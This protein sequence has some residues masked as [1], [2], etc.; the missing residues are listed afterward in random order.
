METLELAVVTPSAV[1]HWRIPCQ[2]SAN[3][4]SAPGA[5]Q[6]QKPFPVFSRFKPSADRGRM[7]V[8][9]YDAVS[10]SDSSPLWSLLLTT[11]TATADASSV[12]AVGGG[13]GKK[14]GAEVLWAQLV[15]VPTKRQVVWE[16]S[17][18][19]LLP[20]PETTTTFQGT[21]AAAA[22]AHVE[23]GV[24]V[25]VLSA[26]GA[27]LAVHSLNE[28]FLAAHFS[29]AGAVVSAG[30]PP[31]PAA[32]S[33]ASSS[34]SLCDGGDIG[35]DFASSSSPEGV[36]E[37]Q[38]A[39]LV[40]SAVGR[41][42]HWLLPVVPTVAKGAA[43]DS[44]VAHSSAVAVFHPRGKLQLI[45]CPL[46]KVSRDDN[47]GFYGTETSSWAVLYEGASVFGEGEHKKGV[48]LLA[49]APDFRDPRSFLFLAATS[50]DVNVNDAE[51]R[52]LKNKEAKRVAV[53]RASFEALLE[54]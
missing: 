22:H 39:G 16:V 13:A 25:V 35:D 26:G 34:L 46:D 23:G 43:E 54:S 50:V 4:P 42:R 49:A 37:E 31:H 40:S 32:Q 18:A 17:A 53:Y 47:E 8:L 44:S 36:G 41:R 20:A 2:P 24:R 15:H 52:D 48:E 28:E 21:V 38:K 19:L 29:A 45:G 11:A 33:R 51:R 12:E 5:P 14:R 9:S 6:S 10:S 7:A 27:E 1:A 3:T 30:P